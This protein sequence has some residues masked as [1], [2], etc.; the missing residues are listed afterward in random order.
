MRES[1]EIIETEDYVSGLYNNYEAYVILLLPYKPVCTFSNIRIVM[2]DFQFI[3]P[4]SNLTLD[5]SVHLSP[6]K[7]FSQMS[8]YSYTLL[9]L[10]LAFFSHIGG[11]TQE[12]PDPLKVGIIPYKNEAALTNT[13]GPLFDRLS[14]TNNISVEVTYLEEK[15]LAYQLSQGMINMGILK[16]IAYLNAK[17]NFPSLT[18]FGTHLVQEKTYYTGGLL[19]RK[20]SGWNTLGDISKEVSFSPQEDILYVKNTSTSGFKFPRNLLKEHGMKFAQDL[21]IFH[22]SGSHQQSVSYLLAGETQLIAID[23]AAYQELADSA[24]NQLALLETYEIPNHA[25]V[26]APT[27]LE[28]AKSHLT[29][30]MF[31][32]HNNP[33]FQSAF[34]NPLHIQQWVAQS[35]EAYNPLRRGL[36][37]NTV[38]PKVKLLIKPKSTAVEIL[39]RKG[40]LLDIF[41]DTFEEELTASG[42][43]S[44]LT[45]YFSD[46]AYVVSI[47]LGVIDEDFFVQAKLRDDFI[48]SEKVGIADL[49]EKLPS[50]LTKAILSVSPISTDL[51]YDGNK[52]F[53]FYGDTDGIEPKNYTFSWV[54][55]E[56]NKHIVPKENILDV[57]DTRIDFSPQ[58]G[59]TPHTPITISFKESVKETLFSFMQNTAEEEGFWDNLDNRWGVIGLVVALLSVITGSY[60]A[61]RKRR[62]FKS[63][64][65]EANES[66]RSYVDEVGNPEHKL[67]TLKERASKSLEKGLIAENQFLILKHRLTD[68]DLIIHRL[69]ATPE[70]SRKEVLTELSNILRSDQ[71][72]EKDVAHI[73]SI[74]RKLPVSSSE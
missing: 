72:S 11:I 61:Q 42:R 68:I 57:A 17:R 19:A 29:Q 54:D 33:A 24:K 39:S 73:L 37:F 32:A 31:Q 74:V 8:R 71:I 63:M 3:Q 56:G 5:K 15:E 50:S 47:S 21:N 70:G 58:E 64:M 36:H 4:G 55:Q 12:L 14:K 26:W 66:L 51:H 48:L 65:L 44:G 43:F 7:I 67:L 59:F 23:L 53:I 28:E 34:N 10:I 30:E 6:C 18:V 41:R 69:D 35:D 22:F 60:L 40:D 27:M 45:S 20:E 62:L 38:K 46:N 1:T 25:Y 9:S 52:W 16:P 2:S 49:Q 13:Y